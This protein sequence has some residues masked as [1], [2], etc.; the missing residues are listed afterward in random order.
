MGRKLKPQ[1]NRKPKESYHYKDL[2]KDVAEELGYTVKSISEILKVMREKMA[3]A[4]LDKKSVEIP[5]IGILYPVIKP[6]RVGVLM[7]SKNMD[8]VIVPAA[9][10]LRLQPSGVIAED[11][12]RLSISQR[13]IEEI[14]IKEED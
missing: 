12:S 10:R 4:L 3:E 7:K 11:L 9:Y 14:Y 5:K 2:E 13:E 6:P 1:K 8:K